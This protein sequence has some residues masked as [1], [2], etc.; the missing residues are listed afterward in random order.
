TRRRRTLLLDPRTPGRDT[1]LAAWR[2]I[3][4]TA[5][6][7][8]IPA[9]PEESAR[10]FDRRLGKELAADAGPDA[11]AALARLRQDYEVAAYANPAAPLPHAASPAAPLPHSASPAAPLPH[12]ATAYDG[13][14]SGTAPS[15]AVSGSLPGRSPGNSPGDAGTRRWT[16]VETVTRA[17]RT[18]GPWHQRLLD[19]LFPRSLF[20]R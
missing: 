13:G 11:A 6:D 4:D 16:D 5:T 10:T 1:A 20:R 7:Y 2:E 3:L 12:A 9:A 8:G 14:P 19:R 17:L 18:R 15:S